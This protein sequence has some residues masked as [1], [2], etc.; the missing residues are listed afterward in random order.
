M[1]IEDFIK[2]HG[3]LTEQYW[4]YDGEV[5]LRY[6]PQ[7]HVY[8]LVTPEGLEKQDGVTQTVHII[9]K[10]N[11]LVPWGVKM[12]YQKLLRT[13][14][15]TDS[16]SIEDGKEVT[17]R[18]T[19]PMTFEE[20]DKIAHEAKDAHKEKLED[21]GEV[22]HTAHAWVE[23]YIKLILAYNGLSDHT[24]RAIADVKI[25]EHLAK[26]PEDERAKNACT[27]ALDWM[28]KHNVRWQATERKIYS[29]MYKYAGTMDG[30]CVC[31]SCEDTKCCPIPF[32]D[33]HTV[34]DWKTSNY[35][36]LE[37]LLQTAAYQHAYIEEMSIADPH[38][39]LVTDRWV[40]RLGKDNG[41]FEAWHCGWE[42]FVEDFE[43]FKEALKLTRRVRKIE[44]RI[45][46]R[47]AGIRA[48]VKAERD[49]AR[50]VKEAQ[51]ALERAE[52][53]ARKQQE[54]TEALALKCT[55]SKTYKGS[56]FPI[57]TTNDGGPC[58]SCIAK[59]NEK[60]VEK[61]K[62]WQDGTKTE[63]KRSTK[64]T[65]ESVNG[66]LAV[67][68]KKQSTPIPLSSTSSLTQLLLTDGNTHKDCDYCCDICGKWANEC[69][70]DPKCSAGN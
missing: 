34:A 10:S 31:D 49:A 46:E 43:G 42:D 21:A 44:G 47:K 6:D 40:I 28:A 8:L 70:C 68:V 50:E 7:E 5:E 14:P 64:H 35:L 39:P 66:L 36:Y 16:V 62:I 45:S 4:F 41:E 32:T 38:G 52:T 48:I 63:V 12:S 33:R 54:R 3:G 23:E 55:K 60:H 2:K 25:E 58:A 67:L 27:A 51:E 57:C 17:R 13:M 9:D 22:G 65:S 11:A 30:L 56:R 53:K 1:A 37:Y 26:M 15:F 61:D 24:D 29:R 59:Y 19:I 20:F 69:T 18:Y